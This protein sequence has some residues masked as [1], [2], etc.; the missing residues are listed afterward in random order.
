VNAPRIS[1]R[2]VNFTPVYS[3]KVWS[4]VQ[5]PYI[6]LPIVGFDSGEVGALWNTGLVASA[7]GLWVIHARQLIS[8]APSASPLSGVA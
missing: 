2:D 7:S 6:S 8:R 4:V 3:R 5:Q 1:F